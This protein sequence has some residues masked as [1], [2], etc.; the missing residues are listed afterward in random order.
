M[1]ETNVPGAV[2][3][4]NEKEKKWANEQRINEVEHGSFTP[5]VFSA[6]DGMAEAVTVA[7]LQ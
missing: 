5:L 7:G 1:Y 3:T 6:T 4:Q 2:Y